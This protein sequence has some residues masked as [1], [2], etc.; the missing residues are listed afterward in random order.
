VKIHILL[1]K[2]FVVVELLACASL[3]QN[4]ETSTTPSA[5]SSEP[6]P[7]RNVVLFV[8]D[9]LRHDSV[10]ADTAPT[11]FRLRQRGVDFVN[12]HSMYPTFTTP[13]ASALATGH[14]L[15][16]TG[17]FGNAL[18][19]GHLIGRDP[20]TAT[21]TPFIENDL[22]LAR[23]NEYYNGNYLGEP[24]LTDLARASGY[25]VAVVGKVGP[26]AIQ[27]IS[28]IQAV[29]N[30]FQPTSAT[31][32][33][34]STGP[35]GIPIPGDVKIEMN[36]SGLAASAPDRSNG[37]DELGPRHSNGR[38]GTLSANFHQQQYLADV[39][40]QAVLPTFRKQLKPFF[41]VF[42]SR[43]PDGTQH[44][45]GD[46]LDQ[47]YPGINGPTSRAAIRN[48]DNDLWQIVDYLKANDLDRDTDVIVVSD[49][50][51]ST[52]SKRETSRTGTPTTSFSASKLYLDVKE[53]YLPPGFLAIDLAH[54]LKK[55]LYDPDAAP[56]VTSDGSYYQRIDLCDCADS[57]F[58]Q[59]SSFGNGLIGGSGRVPAPLEA[60]DADVVIAANGGSDLIYLPQEGSGAAAANKQL[61]QT[62]SAFLAQQDYV[63]G[64]F[65]RDDLGDLPATLPLSAIGLMGST[66]L[67]RPAIVVAFK[68][69]PLGSDPLLTRVEIADSSLQEGQGMHGSL[70]RADTFNTMLAFGPDFKPEYVDHAPASNADIAVTIAA[71]L[72]LKFPDGNGALR[73]RVL[74]EALR[75]SGD[76]PDFTQPPPRTSSQAS[77]KGMKT[78]LHYQT[79]SDHT[80]YDRTCLVNATEDKNPE[81]R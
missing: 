74:S 59:H 13:N 6:A 49:H 12:S 16:D 81:C 10:T 4:A 79:L 78:V 66:K 2:I 61:A 27:D 25:A 34:D 15:G 48:A 80:Y 9:G 71:L 22:L 30:D 7:L 14:G 33:D 43:D 63:D 45:Q 21:L 77:P 57:R 39:A 20:A 5:T 46:S 28:E 53:G 62:I 68:T 32:I 35:Q 24:T 70:S 41:L 67:P 3:A 54:A 52:I 60:T 37:H 56:F 8:A 23:L 42:W 31:V 73:G 58:M 44:N 69:F 26:A 65:V 64:I 18:Y 38:P 50:G 1:A 51:F 75:G 47:L 76:S 29:L 17:D 19:V 40:T 55:P 72:K 36:S 11:M